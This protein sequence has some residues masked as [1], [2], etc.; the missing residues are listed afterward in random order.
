ML[1]SALTR[2]R[3]TGIWEFRF[4]RY[5]TAG[6]HAAMAKPRDNLTRRVCIHTIYAHS[7]EPCTA[8]LFPFFSFQL[9]LVYS[10]KLRNE[11]A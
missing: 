11:V 3:Y 4:A 2:G 10:Y 7:H 5:K 8:H 1:R 6:T 9:A